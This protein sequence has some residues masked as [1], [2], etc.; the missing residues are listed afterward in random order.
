MEVIERGEAM[1]MTCS[2]LIMS[3]LVHEPEIPDLLVVLSEHNDKDIADILWSSQAMLKRHLEQ[4][5]NL[6]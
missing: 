3:G 4:D 5:W 6:N 1:A 2:N